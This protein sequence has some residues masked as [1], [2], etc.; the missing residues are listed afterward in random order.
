M[1]NNNYNA[2][3]S[4]ESKGGGYY[5]VS[6]TLAGAAEVLYWLISKGIP[7]LVGLVGTLAVLQMLGLLF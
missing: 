1:M 3:V 6:E 7:R 4:I 5:H 2:H